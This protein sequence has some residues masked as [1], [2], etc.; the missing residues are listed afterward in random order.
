MIVSEARLAANH[1]NALKST[2]AKT[3]EGKER[4]R[5]NALKHGLCASE[6][7]AEDLATVQERAVAC[8]E[9]IKPQD[10]FQGWLA[11][12]VAVASLRIDRAVRIERRLRD[13]VA[14]HAELRWDDDRR[15][16]VEALGAGL[17]QHPGAVLERLR[18]TP[19]GCDWLMN[20]WALLAHAADAGAW[21]P[22]QLGLAFDLLGTPAAFRSGAPG[23]AIDRDGPPLGPAELARRELAALRRRRDEVADLDVVDR[24]LA[25]ADLTDETT[26]E[27]RR[28]RRYEGSLHRRLRW[29]LAELKYKSPYPTTKHYLHPNYVANLEP[30]PVVETRKLEPEVETRNLEPEPEPEAL[31]G[32]PEP[33]AEAGEAEASSPPPSR[34]ESRAVR[35]GARREAKARKL[36]RLRA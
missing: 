3:P 14:L 29:C 17:A 36:E 24:A 9:A 28:L 6:I 8:F 15:L 1:A 13:K 20:R 11:D 22:D 4:S 5:A 19:H 2:G 12:Q 33:E 35:V 16:E 10:H 25:S 30:E 31:A 21:T 34:R 26:D 32:A 7:V 18:A 23:L 27:I